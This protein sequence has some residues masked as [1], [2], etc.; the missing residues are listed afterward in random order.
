M[1]NRGQGCR[2]V[3]DRQAGHEFYGV[4]QVGCPRQ[5]RKRTQLVE[6]AAEFLPDAQWQRC[7][8]HFYRNVF[9]HVPNNKVKQVALMLKAIHAAE[10]REAAKEKAEAVIE[11]LRAMRL[12]EAAQQVQDGIAETLTYYRVELRT[13]SFLVTKERFITRMSN[14]G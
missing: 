14:S 9:S 1:V 12:K 2:E 13:I 6:S 3:R 11:K 4:L 5:L 10:D 8:V 7:V